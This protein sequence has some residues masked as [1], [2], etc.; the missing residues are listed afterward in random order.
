MVSCASA[1]L[2]SSESEA[3]FD[4]NDNRYVVGGSDNEA[5]ADYDHDSDLSFIVDSDDLEDLDTS[6]GSGSEVEYSDEDDSVVF[7]DSEVDEE[8]EVE[9]SPHVDKISAAVTTPPQIE[10]NK[11]NSDNVFDF[12]DMQEAIMEY[13]PAPKPVKVVADP[14]SPA[15]ERTPLHDITTPLSSSVQQ[16]KLTT[17]KGTVQEFKRSRSALTRAAYSD[18][19]EKCFGGHLPADLSVTWNKRLRTTAGVTKMKKVTG[20]MGV[21]KSATIE[22]SDKVVDNEERLKTTLLH[23]MCHA[24]AWL[25]DSQKKPPHGPAFWKWASIAGAS[26]GGLVVTTCHS[27]EIHK[28]FK[29]VCTNTL[30]G[31]EYTRHSKKGIDVDRHRC[32]KCRSK[33]K[34]LGAFNADKTPRKTAK[35]TGFSLF[36]QENF[37]TVKSK[38]SK[39]GQTHKDVMQ[40]LSRMYAQ[41][42]SAATPKKAEDGGG[43]SAV[44]I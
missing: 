11:S 37:A 43:D 10:N 7:S 2:S 42:K 19:N 36:V 6:S 1:A 21:V 25:I 41:S 14:R 33:I 44:V 27:Y 5:E 26:S 28:P 30:C 23:E 12:G 16:Q 3:E 17:G 34:F 9:P 15:A 32:G 18:F 22:L 29:F 13:T 35:A 39:K 40:E 20:P 38:L 24:A 8:G 31:V 4:E